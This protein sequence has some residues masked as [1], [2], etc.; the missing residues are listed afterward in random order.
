MIDVVTEQKQ[1]VTEWEIAK[2]VFGNKRE[3]FITLTKYNTL[4]RREEGKPLPAVYY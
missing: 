4:Q 3:I 1:K 2:T